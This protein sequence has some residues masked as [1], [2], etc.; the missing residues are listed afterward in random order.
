[1]G[2]LGEVIT[3]VPE[4]LKRSS[5][6]LTEQEALREELRALEP[7]W[8]DMQRLQE[9]LPNCQQRLQ[10]LAEQQTSLASLVK[11]V[12]WLQETCMID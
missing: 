9:E 12:L 7:S 8:Q 6:S 11:Q 3:N 10:A 5:D 1:M 2:Q 4:S